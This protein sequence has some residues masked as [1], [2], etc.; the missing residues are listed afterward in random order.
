MMIRIQLQIGIIIIYRIMKY[1]IQYQRR[2]S[3]PY[4]NHYNVLVSLRIQT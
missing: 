1:I 3:K 4:Y 2:S